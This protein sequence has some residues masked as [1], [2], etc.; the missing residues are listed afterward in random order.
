[1]P[2][3]FDKSFVR[4]R[5][6]LLLLLFILTGLFSIILLRTNLISLD[7]LRK[8]VSGE[9]NSTR[10]LIYYFSAILFH[11]LWFPR[12]W[13][14]IVAGLLF[15][16]LWGLLF[17][18]FADLTSA[19]LTFGVARYLGS[20]QIHSWIQKNEKLNKVAEIFQEKK[21][22]AMTAI[23]RALPVH[24]TGL[25]YVAGLSKI[26]FTPYFIGTIVGIIPGSLIFVLVGTSAKHPSSPW[27]IL[28]LA[29]M[30]FVAL[31]GL[32]L[33]SRFWRSYKS[34]EQ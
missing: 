12:M 31:L 34:F 23:L 33:M 4:F 14:L 32:Y 13:T 22:F 6:L 18:A 24:Y 27:F 16:P 7:V 17:S 29:I 3:R 19:T 21:G 20:D 9:L 28:S 30:T 10:V 1:M 8:L 15:H 11:M 5:F 2:K 25:G 26:R